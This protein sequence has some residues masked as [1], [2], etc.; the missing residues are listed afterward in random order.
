MSPLLRL[1]SETWSAEHGET[2]WL[3]WLAL[4]VTENT[5]KGFVNKPW[6]PISSHKIS[7]R[8]T[9]YVIA[10][11]KGFLKIEKKNDDLIFS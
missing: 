3:D 4:G 9:D 11:Y 6:N 7:L 1:R 5:P 8:V 2:L 10:F